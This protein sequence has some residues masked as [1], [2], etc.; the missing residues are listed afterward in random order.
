MA[1]SFSNHVP[2]PLEKL[3]CFC[4]TAADVCTANHN[5]KA[6][7]RRNRSQW[8]HQQ[9]KT[10]LTLG[11]IWLRRV[12]GSYFL[13]LKEEKRQSW[14]GPASTE[15]SNPWIAAVDQSTLQKSN[16]IPPPPSQSPCCSMEITI[17]PI[18]DHDG[19]FQM[20]L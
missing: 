20:L 1:I 19:D 18:S 11:H 7:H 8:R 12:E 10:D 2:L 9:Q 6:L 3:P 4:G 16:L 17:P 5:G 15:G 14:T 13:V